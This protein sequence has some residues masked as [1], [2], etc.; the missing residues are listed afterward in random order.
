MTVLDVIVVLL[1]YLLFSGS[2]ATVEDT[3]YTV[4]EDAGVVAV[5]ISLDQPNCQPVNFIVLPR[6]QSPVDA[7]CKQ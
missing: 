6:V 7:S 5:D 3:S 4:V 2:V 1:K